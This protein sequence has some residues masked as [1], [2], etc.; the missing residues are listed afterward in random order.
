MVKVG[1]DLLEFPLRPLGAS[2]LHGSLTETGGWTRGEEDE[3]EEREYGVLS[4][5]CGQNREE[6][7]MG[8]KYHSC[9]LF[10]NIPVLNM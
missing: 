2:P 9:V 6:R 7:T 10:S 3:G 4:A 8:G 5:K 1:M